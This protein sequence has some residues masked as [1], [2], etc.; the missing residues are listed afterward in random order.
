MNKNVIFLMITLKGK[1][2]THLFLIVTEIQKYILL[3]CD[4]NEILEEKL[5]K[6][7]SVVQ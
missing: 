4:F 3:M 6:S 7:I 1:K 2:A 5:V